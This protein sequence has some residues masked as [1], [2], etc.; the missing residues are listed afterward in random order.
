MPHPAPQGFIPETALRH[1]QPIH[2][3]GKKKKCWGTENSCLEGVTHQ[4]SHLQRDYENCV[5]P[6]GKTVCKNQWQW[7]FKILWPVALKNQPIFFNQDIFKLIAPNTSSFSWDTDWGRPAAVAPWLQQG[8]AG[9]QECSRSPPHPGETPTAW[10]KGRRNRSRRK[11]RGCGVRSIHY[12][13]LQSQAEGVAWEMTSDQRSLGPSCFPS[14]TSSWFHKRC[15][16]EDK[17]LLQM[18]PSLRNLFGLSSLP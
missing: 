15:G 4:P 14:S 18:L 13:V 2:S 8:P 9:V 3:D 5:F 17:R 11:A 1:L 12:V 7:W 6:S 10:N 16:N